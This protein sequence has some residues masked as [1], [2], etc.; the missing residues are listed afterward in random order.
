MKY[1]FIL[2]VAFQLLACSKKTEQAPLLGKWNCV[3]F[4]TQEAPTVKQNLKEGSYLEF[5]ETMVISHLALEGEDFQDDELTYTREGNTLN[6]NGVK[7]KIE[8]LN[9][10]N[11]RISS[12]LTFYL[13]RSTN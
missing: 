1:C 2:L 8:E 4:T 11:L 10:T 3:A 9:T 5:K 13:T 12:L 6:M 7:Y